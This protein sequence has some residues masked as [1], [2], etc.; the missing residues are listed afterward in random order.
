MKGVLKMAKIIKN[1]NGFAGLPHFETVYIENLN[2]MLHEYRDGI[3]VLDLTN[4]LQSGKSC[5][6]YSFTFDDCVSGYDG[7]IRY[8]DTFPFS[9][10]V[11]NCR[12]GLYA[13]NAANLKILGV[14]YHEYQQKGVKTFSPWAKVKAQNLTGKINGLKFAKAIAA[15]Q[16]TKAICTG[17][18]TDD[19]Y[20]DH[21]T[22]YAKGK[23]K[24]L[25][26][27]A[28]EVL[29]DKEGLYI[30]PARENQQNIV[31][32]FGGYVSYDAVMA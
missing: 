6:G 24:N 14:H 26:D 15:G 9:C 23:A 32:D 17:R 20:L 27:L 10:F 16:I 8:L 28:A 30:Y 19:Y 13:K 4:A 18:Y 2:I 1:F 29:Q 31:V 11:A 5:N 7:L 22:N 25:L 3:R 21:I 12:A